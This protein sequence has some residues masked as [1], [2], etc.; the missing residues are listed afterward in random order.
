MLSDWQP[1]SGIVKLINIVE[2]FDSNFKVTIN[3][4]LDIVRS[5]FNRLTS[6]PA[7]NLCKHIG[8]TLRHVMSKSL[9]HC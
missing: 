4:P 9:N 2:V 7:I 3:L 6:Y 5:M 1:M 8:Q